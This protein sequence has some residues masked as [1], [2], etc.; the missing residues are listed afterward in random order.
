MGIGKGGGGGGVGRQ[1]AKCGVCERGGWGGSGV[2]QPCL[3]LGLS[4]VWRV[5]TLSVRRRGQPA[6]LGRDKCHFSSNAGQGATVEQCSTHNHSATMDTNS[7][8]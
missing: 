3:L 1:K 8:A 4:P 2:L 6:R 5:S 7:R